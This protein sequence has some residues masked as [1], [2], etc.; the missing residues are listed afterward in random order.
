MIMTDPQYPRSPKVLLGG[1]AH[2]GRFV[3]KVRLRNAGRVQDYD[4]THD[5]KYFQELFPVWINYL[6]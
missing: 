4:Y 6:Q 1:I 2:R 5:Y 3:N